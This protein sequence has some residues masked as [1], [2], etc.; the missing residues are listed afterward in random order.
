MHPQNWSGNFFDGLRC[1]SRADGNQTANGRGLKS[2]VRD[3]QAALR[4]YGYLFGLLEGTGFDIDSDDHSI[5]N[6]GLPRT[7]EVDNE[8]S[9]ALFFA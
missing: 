1:K 5:G 2:F 9:F 6:G 3:D 7:L 8:E 4:G